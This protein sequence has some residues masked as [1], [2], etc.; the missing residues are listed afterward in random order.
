LLDQI[1]LVAAARA[2]FDLPQFAGR[3]KRQ[4]IGCAEATSPGFRWRQVGAGKGIGAHRLRCLGNFGV[5]WRIDQWNGGSTVFPEV[6]ITWGGFAIQRQAQ[7]LAYGLV[8]IL[9]W[10]HALA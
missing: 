9:G 3:R 8:R 4:T 2:M 10:G 5:A 1:Q 6:G 7:D